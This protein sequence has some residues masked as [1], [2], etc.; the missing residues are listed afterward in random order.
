MLTLNEKKVLKEILLSFG[1][2]NSINT[3]AKKCKLSPNGAYKILVKFEEEGILKA[4][5][6]NIKSYRLDFDNPKTDSMI[7]LSLIH[8][9]NALLN[10]RVNDLKGLKETTEA[11]L[12]FGSYLKNPS[13]ANDLDILLLLK[14][15]NFKRV[16]NSLEQARLVSPIK[17][18][19]IL[20]TEEDI[21]KNIYIRDAVIFDIIKTGIIL[22]GHKKIINV[23][24]NVYK[25]KIR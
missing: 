14:K 18:H 10:N 13:K 20:Q 9:T 8:E 23:I 17:L 7:E 16:Q 6:S 19:E 24:K 2:G 11:G 25:Q 1:E 21:K 5:I 12:A 15:E 3:I 22:W 4:T